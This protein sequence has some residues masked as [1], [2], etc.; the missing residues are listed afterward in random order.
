MATCSG[1]RVKYTKVKFGVAIIFLLLIV[2]SNQV[3]ALGNLPRCEGDSPNSTWHNCYGV[4]RLPSGD[5]FQ[6]EFRDGQRNGYGI[7]YYANS[8]RFEGAYR[9]DERNGQGV[10]Y[11][12]SGNQFHGDRF[13]SYYVNG[14]Q[15]GQ[16]IYYRGKDRL[17]AGF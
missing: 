13:E 15:Y 14:K 4:W 9:N 11:H 10:Y 8:D 2:S 7:Y 5:L 17:T 3:F 16:G 1:L 12:L 6:G